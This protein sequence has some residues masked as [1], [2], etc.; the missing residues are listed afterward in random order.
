MIAKLGSILVFSILLG[1]NAFSL[2]PI[3]AKAF[4]GFHKVFWI[5]LENTDSPVALQQPFLNALAKKGAHL[6]NMTAETHPSQ[7]NY[8]AMIA[9]DTL[10]V[11]NDKN[12]DLNQTHLGDLLEAKGLTWKAYAEGYP[13]NCFLGASSGRYVRKHV[14]FLSFTNV[15]RNLARCARIVDDTQFD[16]DLAN[17]NL[18]NFSFFAPNMDNI[19]HDTDISYADRYMEKRFGKLLSDPNFLKD[20]LVVIT[21]DES[22]SYLHN[23]IYTVLLG[24]GVAPAS[25][26]SQA[27]DHTNLLKMIEGEWQLGTLG[28]SD[29]SASPIDG[30]WK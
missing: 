19:G 26:N 5:V 17:N 24:A 12:V 14:P 30:I 2:S 3:Q 29:Q 23:D 15:S 27:V 20:T 6:Q 10:G 22:E 9:G 21:F 11:W 8:I 4:K 13:G 28:R 18:P 16:L 1:F 25:K 7:G